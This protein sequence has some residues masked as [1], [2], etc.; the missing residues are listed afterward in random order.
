MKEARTFTFNDLGKCPKVAIELTKDILKNHQ[1]QFKPGW[2]CLPVVNGLPM[3]S[4]G[5]LIL[6][7]RQKDAVTATKAAFV[8]NTYDGKMTDEEAYAL[9]A[10]IAGI[11]LQN[12]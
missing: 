7:V 1:I 11:D 9:Q 2:Y 5:L 3:I 6:A 10:N 12:L 4:D 8:H